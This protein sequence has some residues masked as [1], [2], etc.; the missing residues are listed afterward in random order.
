MDTVTKYKPEPW[1]PA[2]LPDVPGMGERGAYKN[3]SY[4]DAANAEKA[5]EAINSF[6]WNDTPQGH[7]FWAIVATELRRIS[8]WYG[9]SKGDE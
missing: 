9:G 5:F 6:T 8:E 3:M 7:V 4:S 1:K 2:L